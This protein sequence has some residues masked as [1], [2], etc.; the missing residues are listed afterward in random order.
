MPITWSANA[1]FSLTV[2]FGS[3]RK[4]WNTVPIWRRSRG[5]FQLAR[6]LISLPAT[7]TRPAVGRDSRSTSLRAVDLPDPEAPT[8]KTNSPFSTSMET[9]SRAEWPW[10]G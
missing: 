5:T 8:R 10:P 6:R 7:Y 4:S 9:L 1:T 3:S 2:L